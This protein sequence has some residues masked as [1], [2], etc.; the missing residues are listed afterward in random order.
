MLCAAS[1]I[2]TA[3]IMAIFW[4][5]S[6]FRGHSVLI[7]LAAVFSG[8]ALSSPGQRPRVVDR[9]VAA[10]LI[11]ISLAGPVIVAVNTHKVAFVPTAVALAVGMI[12]AAVEQFL[13]LRLAEA[14]GPWTVQNSGV[15]AT[16][17]LLGL[18]CAG[19]YLADGGAYVGS[20]ALW[21]GA[22]GLLLTV[23][24]VAPWIS[25]QF[26]PV[27]TAEDEG[28]AAPLL[29]QRKKDS[30]QVIAGMTGLALISMVSFIIGT[31]PA[32]DWRI[33]SWSAL[34]T[35]VLIISSVTLLV[36]TSVL[37]VASTKPSPQ[38]LASV[39]GLSIWTICQCLLFALI[40][41][42]GLK[43]NLIAT[44]MALVIGLFIAEGIRGNLSS[45]HNLPFDGQ[46]KLITVLGGMAAASTVLWLVGL[47]YSVKHRPSNLVAALIA[48]LISV[49]AI[50]LLPY[51]AAKS[52]HRD[53]PPKQFVSAAPLA[54]VLQDSF[55][56]VL[57][58][59]FV[60][61]VPVLVLA[62]LASLDQS[63]AVVLAYVG[64]FSA[65]YV[66]IMRNNVKHVERTF[67]TAR[68]KSD[69]GIIPVDQKSAL[70]GL[71]RHCQNQNAL[72][73]IALLP[74][75]LIA[76]LQIALEM[77]G[78]KPNAGPLDII[79]RLL[80]PRGLSKTQFEEI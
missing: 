80:M 6:T 46:V 50:Q 58:A 55:I 76:M 38:S 66:Y 24:V 51:L 64:Y 53:S 36:V 43:G 11:A 67:K 17:T 61:W 65:A 48:L 45:L 9:A 62:H 22:V 40:Q 32:Q 16:G 31:T 77:A 52:L 33:G 14:T 72:A 13:L 47:T 28:V 73:L 8:V 74:L 49:V 1:V 7:A 59:V 20:H 2:P 27:I 18:T 37:L 79:K 56:S 30:Y 21:F 78:F 63:G 57:L 5:G 44:Y 75:T 23:L 34:L 26:E 15:L 19:G 12:L 70:E 10:S 25:G 4:P 54:G 29:S 69:N 41:P 42:V 68:E 39:I 71:R 3:A 35:V 60:G